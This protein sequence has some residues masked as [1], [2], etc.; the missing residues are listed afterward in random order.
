MMT[1]SAEPMVYSLG[2]TLSRFSGFFYQCYLIPLVL[3]IVVLN[4]DR[5]DNFSLGRL[6]AHGACACAAAAA[7]Y[8]LLG[9]AFPDFKDLGTVSHMLLLVFIVLY[10]AFFSPLPLQVRVV[11]TAAVVADIN[12]AQS[13]ST[14]VFM[15]SLSMGVSN[16]LQ[17]L[18]LVA[19]LV[20]VVVFRPSRSGRIP[21]A[22][23]LTM[24]II[25]V[26]STV[27]LY[28]IRILESSRGYLGEQN[29][30]LCITLFAFFIV[31]HLVYFLYHSLVTAHRAAM[32]MST[33]QAKL[34]QDLEFYRRSETLTQEFR[35]IRHELKNHISLMESLLAD[36]NYDRLRQYFEDYSGK[37]SPLVEEFLCPNALVSSVITHQ[38][39]TARTAGVQLDVIAAVPERLGIADD[40]L[41]SLLS[42][43][44][45]NGV[46]G[47]LR[48]GKTT[49]KATLH[50]DRNC[51]FIT[52]TNPAPADTLKIN[53]RL[54]STKKNPLSHGFGIPIIR[55]IA[56]RYDGIVR[57]TEEN[58]WFTADA[59]LYL[60]E[61]EDG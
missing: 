59:M 8:L 5:K 7:L 25:A 58:G 44:L 13:I 19:S 9:P 34:E 16:A 39:N 21:R 43:L 60:E 54:R 3:A 15:P 30:T 53:P 1:A 18:L 51:L 17:F 14:Q 2:S 36:K 49:V 22:Y 50:T 42:N 61:G 37:I 10:A 40:D 41:C 52:V 47:C 57:F 12:W 6:A 29:I 20:L 28:A 11:V 56:E 46:E 48:A 23:W 38:M 33:M 45:D 31:N 32:D 24:L 26:L 35:S 55:Q 27:C 4:M